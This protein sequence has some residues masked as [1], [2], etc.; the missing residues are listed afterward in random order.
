MISPD[1][2]E[3]DLQAIFFYGLPS[4]YDVEEWK[5]ILENFGHMRVFYISP[6]QVSGYALYEKYQQAA[7]AAQELDQKHWPE[8]SSNQISVQVISN[9]EIDSAIRLGVQQLQD[10]SVLHPETGGTLFNIT[11]TEP[12]IYWSFAKSS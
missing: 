4:T 7:A 12:P 5:N 1:P 9:E 11:K 8:G 3:N 6:S 10:I 2:L